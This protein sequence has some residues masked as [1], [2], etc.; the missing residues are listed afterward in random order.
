MQA[1]VKTALLILEGVQ[2]T[3][4]E[5]MKHVLSYIGYMAKERRTAS[6]VWKRKFTL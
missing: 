5:H 3:A 6:G 1:P 4:Q 2:M